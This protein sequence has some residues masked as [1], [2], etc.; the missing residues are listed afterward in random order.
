[1]DGSWVC[2]SPCRPVEWGTWPWS[3]LWM[4]KVVAGK[5]VYERSSSNRYRTLRGSVK[6]ILE[7]P[8][9]HIG[10]GGPIWLCWRAEVGWLARQRRRGQ[11]HWSVLGQWREARTGVLPGW[12]AQLLLRGHVTLGEVTLAELLLLEV[13]TS[14][15]SKN[16]VTIRTTCACHKIK[17]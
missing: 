11:R 5:D 12:L 6:C 15:Y 8:G 16:T 14:A 13:M 4:G 10:Q 2:I 9:Q 7:D 3:S 17:V 1:M